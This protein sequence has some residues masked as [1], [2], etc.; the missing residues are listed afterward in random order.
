MIYQ[1][2][3]NLHSYKS[4]NLFDITEDVLLEISQSEVDEGLI[5]IFSMSDSRIT[6]FWKN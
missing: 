6:L 1:S 5:S 2:S 3:F 4:A